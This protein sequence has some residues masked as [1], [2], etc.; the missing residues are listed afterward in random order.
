[1]RD[2]QEKASDRQAELDAL[3]AKR[4]IELADRQAREKE[5]KEAEK[6]VILIHTYCDKFRQESIKNCSKLENCK[7]LRRK[8]DCKNKQEMTEM[9][10]RGLL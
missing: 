3:R 8:I 4:A 6:R 10:S 5:K 9:S 1:M 2:K 7:L